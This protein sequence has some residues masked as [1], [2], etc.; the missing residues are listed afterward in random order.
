MNEG[1]LVVDASAIVEMALATER[2]GRIQARLAR[3][4]AALHVPELCPIEVVSA[5]RA[6]ALSGKLAASRAAAAVAD[7]PGLALSRHS[8][9][10]MLARIWQL[11]DTLT[12]YDACYVTLAERLD[13]PL[14]VAD[15][16][17]DT[18]AVR[19]LIDVEVVS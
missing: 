11:R 10:P 3:D 18:L 4:D 12:S 17:L 8:A 15:A 19:R 2:G 13:A 16:K 9:Q 7:L 6:L 5:L 1:A 14:I